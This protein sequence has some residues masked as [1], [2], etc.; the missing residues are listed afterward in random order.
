MG[1]VAAAHCAPSVLED[2]AGE[3]PT[4][5][6]GAQPCH[7]KLSGRSTILIFDWDDTLLCSTAVRMQRWTVEELEALEVAIDS[8]L[9]KAMQ[10]GETLIVTN[11]NE[12]WVQD[13]ASRFL[14]GLLPLLGKLRVVSAR[15]LYEDRYPG[16][17]CMWKHA[18]FEQ[19]LTRERH[20]SADAG[21]NLVALGDQ[22]PEIDAAWHVGR[23]L[24]G[25]SLVKTVKFREQPSAAE[26]LGQ[27]GAMEAALEEVVEGRES[28]SFGLVRDLPALFEPFANA[29][30]GW[31]CVTAQEECGRGCVDPAAGIKE[32]V[33]LF[34]H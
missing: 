29:T 7:G 32:I 19:L 12:N 24:G 28:Q 1:A 33:G 17:L 26:L 22:F 20:F 2:S 10:L 16:D 13:S 27:V 5:K 9:R 14:P 15:A 4:R 18:A 23:L 25:Q 31:K 8:I 3:A 11:G 6:L 21:V 34:A 30:S